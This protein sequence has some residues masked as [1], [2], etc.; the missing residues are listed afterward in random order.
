MFQQRPD[1]FVAKQLLYISGRTSLVSLDEIQK[2]TPL[3]FASHTT[4]W[5][6]LHNVVHMLVAKQFCK[7]WIKLAWLWMKQPDDV[8]SLIPTFL[9]RRNYFWAQ[10]ALLEKDVVVC[11][12]NA[13]TKRALWHTFETCTLLLE[14]GNNFHIFWQVGLI[15][16]D[17][18]HLHQK[19]WIPKW[20][21]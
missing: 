5:S 16:P 9:H 13:S 10:N 12:I 21:H 4:Q 11:T 17:V 19:R 8:S 15:R 3:C 7:K 18:R 20:M 2:K 14:S 1:P 6:T